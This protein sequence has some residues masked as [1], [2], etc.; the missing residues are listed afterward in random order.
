MHRIHPRTALSILAVTAL[1]VAQAATAQK[2]QKHYRFSDNFSSGSLNNWQFPFPEDWAVQQEGNTHYLHMLRMR[3]ALRPSR[4]QQFALLRGPNVGNFTFQTRLRR[5]HRSVI[6]VFDYVDSLHFY[7]AHLSMDSGAERPVHNGIF[8]VDGAPRRRIT[9]LEAPAALPDTNWH[10]VRVERNV[11]A[12]TIKIFVDKQKKPLFSV[13][14]RT[15]LCGR[16]GMGSFDETGDF[17]D[18]KLTSNDA[19]CTPEIAATKQG[20][21]Q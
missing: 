19:G 6:L 11:K 10:T 4:P 14:D 2:T 13:V 5:Y 17:T 16:V 21:P 20:D 12:G 1:L 15:F 8:I 3:K 7:Y 18:V 9:G